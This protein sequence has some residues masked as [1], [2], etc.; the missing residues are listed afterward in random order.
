MIQQLLSVI[1]L[2][3]L[4]SAQYSGPGPTRPDAGSISINVT[5]I[6]IG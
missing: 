4:V 1:V 2:V 5:T 6:Y 3:G